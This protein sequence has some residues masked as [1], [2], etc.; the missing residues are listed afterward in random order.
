MPKSFIVIRT[1]FP[2]LHCWPECPFE[3][4]A[5]LKNPHRHVF[6]VEMKFETTEDRQIEFIRQKMDI[7]AYIMLNFYGRFLERISCETIAAN[8][9]KYFDAFFVSVFED[10]ENGAEWY[11]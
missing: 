2:A 3:D 8:L 11:A 6:H 5:Y 9:G 1:S 7:D 10:D 4:V